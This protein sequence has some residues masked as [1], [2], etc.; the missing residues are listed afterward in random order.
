MQIEQRLTPVNFSVGRGG[1]E[2]DVI[3]V[4]VSEG[5][6]S[7]MRTWFRDPASEVS[8]HY[9]I[10]RAEKPIE[11]YVLEKDRAWSNGRVHNPTAALVLARPTTNPNRYTISIECEGTGLDELTDTQ[12]GKLLW[13]IRD[14]Q[15]RRPLITTDRDHIIRHSEIFARKT[16][17][18]QIDVDR[19]V[20]ELSPTPLP[21]GFPRVVWSGHFND[22][23]VVTRY[24]SDRDWSFVPL[25]KVSKAGQ[26]K[27]A[28]PLSAMPLTP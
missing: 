11:Q 10:P 24:A 13:L 6:M 17:P 20:R 5:T 16:C 3:V 21:G 28:T 7:S 4:H 25:G 23:L 19:L 15:S 9:A 22:W 26:I 12:R 14:I 1:V 27:A 8:A 2:P 18:G